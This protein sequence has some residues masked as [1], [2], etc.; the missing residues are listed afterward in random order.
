MWSSLF[1]TCE[2]RSKGSQVALCQ[3]QKLA[4]HTGQTTISPQW[5]LLLPWSATDWEISSPNCGRVAAKHLVLLQQDKCVKKLELSHGTIE[6]TIEGT[7]SP[8]GQLKYLKSCDS[9]ISDREPHF[10]EELRG[11]ELLLLPELPAYPCPSCDCSQLLLKLLKLDFDG[12]ESWQVDRWYGALGQTWDESQSLQLLSAG[13]T[14]RI[15]ERETS[16]YIYI[17][18]HIHIYKQ[19]LYIYI[20]TYY[21]SR[22]LDDIF[23]QRSLSGLSAVSDALLANHPASAE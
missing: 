12:F 13:L 17:Y 9:V 4:R 2:L 1:E 8:L 5:P 14:L 11:L 20:H 22:L 3:T 18:T 23:E 7:R 15:L 16:I 19:S 21:T 6:G 10:S